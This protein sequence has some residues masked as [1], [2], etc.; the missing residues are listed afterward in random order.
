MHVGFAM[1]RI[2][3]DEADRTLR[4]LAELGEMQRELEAMEIPAGVSVQ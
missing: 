4:V 3:V 2:D 1:S